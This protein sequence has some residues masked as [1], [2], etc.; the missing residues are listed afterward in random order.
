MLNMGKVKV[1]EPKDPL[2]GILRQPAGVGNQF[3]TCSTQLPKEPLCVW[4]QLPVVMYG[5]VSGTVCS[6]QK[7]ELSHVAC[8]NSK[9]NGG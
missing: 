7:A 2:F 6:H 5:V 9:H 4:C 1:A 8:G 3:A